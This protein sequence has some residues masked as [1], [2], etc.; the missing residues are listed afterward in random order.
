MWL[1]GNVLAE[2][3]L[4]CRGRTSSYGGRN[5]YSLSRFI[6]ENSHEALLMLL[7]A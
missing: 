6:F 4:V 5:G 7:A 1:E 2:K 3:Q